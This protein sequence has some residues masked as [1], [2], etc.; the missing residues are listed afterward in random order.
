MSELFSLFEF[1]VKNLK[2]MTITELALKTELRSFS[3]SLAK[4]PE[5]HNQIAEEL[6]ALRKE[7]VF[8]SKLIKI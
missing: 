6:K 2:E 3:Y 4:T 8:R 5:E 1:W 7:L